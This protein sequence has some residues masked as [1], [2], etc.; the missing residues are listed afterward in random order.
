MRGSEFIAAACPAILCSGV[1]ARAA[2]LIKIVNVPTSRMAALKHFELPVTLRVIEDLRYR[3]IRGPG[4][5]F[6]CVYSRIYEGAD[7]IICSEL[8]SIGTR[9]FWPLRQVL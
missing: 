6:V 8:N 4:A 3:G 9:P 5:I 7:S 2:T 1:C